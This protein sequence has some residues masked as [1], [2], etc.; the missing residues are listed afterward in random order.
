MSSAPRVELLWWEGCPSTGDAARLCREEMS[1]VGID[2]AA[3]ELRRIDDAEQAARE[4]FPGSPTIRVE[5]ADVEE[6]GE[7]PAA[8]SC[9]VYRHADGR[10]SPLPERAAVRAALRA[11][12]AAR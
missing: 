1:A 10:F 9:R 6:P 11:A 2:P 7:Q 3:L 5:G 8:L 4:R 12:T